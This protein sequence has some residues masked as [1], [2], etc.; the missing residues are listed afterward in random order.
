LLGLRA[1]PGRPNLRRR[2]DD[3]VLHA[4]EDG[5]DLFGREALEIAKL[6]SDLLTESVEAL[7]DLAVEGKAHARAR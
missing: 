7:L 6:H 2:S 1:G 5:I 3:V 4:G